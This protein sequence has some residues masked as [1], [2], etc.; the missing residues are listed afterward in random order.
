MPP[1]WLSPPAIVYV[2]LPFLMAMPL[3]AHAVDAYVLHQQNP[4]ITGI[5]IGLAFALIG[6]L[7]YV[8]YSLLRPTTKPMDRMELPQ[9]P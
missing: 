5:V 4:L 6:L 2:T 9:E 7:T 3:S 1:H 8:I